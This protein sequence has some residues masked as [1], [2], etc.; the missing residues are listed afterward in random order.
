MVYYNYVVECKFHSKYKIKPKI[1][2]KNAKFCV[3]CSRVLGSPSYT[4]GLQFPG[5]TVSFL[6]IVS[7]QCPCH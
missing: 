4:Y 1:C 6:L 7:L 2:A 3:T 5:V